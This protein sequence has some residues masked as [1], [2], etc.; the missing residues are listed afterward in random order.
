MNAKHD[1]TQGVALARLTHD[2]VLR[3]AG[4]DARAFLHGQLTNDIE[5]LPAD[6]VRRAG[7]C[8]AK[9]RLLATLL[10]VP[11]ADDFLLLLPRELVVSVMKRLRMFVLR[12]KAT[13]DDD[14]ER[15]E[16]FGL[17][18][19]GALQAFATQKGLEVPAAVHALART[20]GAIVVRVEGDRARLLVPAGEAAALVERL[21]LRADAE[22]HWMLEDIRM[23]LPQ[24]VAATQELFVPQMLNFEAIAGLDFKKG[25]Y[26][27]QEIVARAQYRGQVKRHMRRARVAGSAAPAVGQDLFRDDLPGQ[28]CGTVVAVATL[29]GD[30]ELLAVVPTGAAQGQPAVRLAPGGAALEW[31]P[32][33]YAA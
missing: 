30:S 21:G 11:Q 25:C 9:G 1:R 12:A 8:T 28:A 17:L 29:D 32:L 31:L 10:V 20:Q 3:V 33:P 19:N 5:H 22:S 26:P 18:G 2:G 27:G 4:A 16:Q 14:S 24:V 7:W 23:G 6:R 15:W 13:V